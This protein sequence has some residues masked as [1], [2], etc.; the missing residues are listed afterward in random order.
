MDSKGKDVAAGE[1]GLLLYRGGTVRDSYGE[2][3]FVRA[4][5]ICKELNFTY[6]MK[7]TNNGS[8]SIQRNYDVHISG[9]ECHD[10]DWK[11]CHHYETDY[12]KHDNDVYLSCTG[13]KTSVNEIH[14]RILESMVSSPI[15]LTD[16]YVR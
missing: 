6:A 14:S 13:K 8:F 12:D 10:A 16:N 7:W 2:S 5:A 11:S 9:I 15:I 1:L 3:D 4:D